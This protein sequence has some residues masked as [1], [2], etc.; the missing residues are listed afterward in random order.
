MTVEKVSQ[1]KNIWLYSGSFDPFTIG[2]LDIAKRASSLCDQLIIAVFEKPNSIFSTTDR[3]QMILRALEGYDKIKVI[4]FSGLLA[5]VCREYDVKVI[6]RGLR[7]TLDFAYEAPMAHINHELNQSLETVYLI[8]KNEY[9]HISAS[10]VRE[11][12]RYSD[13]LLGMV[14][15]QNQE[16]VLRRLKTL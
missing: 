2:H 16:F 4:S 8:A 10:N 15:E 7:N 3:R 11:L 5:Q 1:A 12:G 13:N 14:P 6:V 9:T